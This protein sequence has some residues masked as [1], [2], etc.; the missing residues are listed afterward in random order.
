MACGVPVLA[1]PVGIVPDIIKPGK[2][3]EIIDWQAEDMARKAKD[4]LFNTEKYEK[5]RQAGM[6][7]AKEFEKK[8]AIKNYAEQL[9]RLITK[10]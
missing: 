6:V 1:T 2:S 9:K 4:L 8:A 10:G 3:G 7:I 5:Y